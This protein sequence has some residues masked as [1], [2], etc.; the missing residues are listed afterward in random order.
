MR[1]NAFPFIAPV[2]PC[3]LLAA[4]VCAAPLQLHVSPEGADSWSGMWAKR[5]RFSK[6]EGPFRTLE[7]ARNEIREQK[8]AGSLPEDG[9][10]VVLEPGVYELPEP[11][12]LTPEDS[13][14]QSAPIV[15]RAA[16]RGTAIL[17]GGVILGGWRPADTPAAQ[18][19][20]DSAAAGRLLCTD[21]GGDLID[22]IPG[23]ANGGCGF[24]GEA[25]YPLALY[26]AS[27]R[28]PISRWP[29]S[30]FV[31]VGECL[32]HNELHGHS[33]IAFT[34]G[35]FRFENGRL[36]RW[37][38][39][40]ELWFD[41]LWFHHWADQ[42]M[43][44]KAIDPREQTISL[45][46]P[47]THRFGYK[48][49][50]GFFAFNAIGEIDRPGE[51]AVDRAER[52]IHL[53]PAADPARNPVTLA[54]R[55]NLIQAEGV[56]DIHFEDLV[57]E[58][59]LETAIVVRN[60]TRVSVSGSTVRHTGSWG[61]DID[62]GSD[63]TVFGCDLYDLGEGGVKASGGIQETLTPGNHVIENNHIHHFGVVVNTYRYGAAVYGVG[64]TIRHNLL[65]HAQHTALFFRGNDHL[66]E[67]N[68]IHDVCLHSSDAGAIHPCARDW[69]LRGCVIRHNFFHATG[70][71]VD[72]CGCHGIYLDD[73]T[74]GV[75]IVGNICSMV[76][77][78][79]TTCG[80]GNR[81]ENNLSIN[82][83]KS[84]FELS[85]RG[86]DSFARAN[87]AKGTE[88]HLVKKLLAKGSPYRSETWKTRYPNLT[89]LLDMLETDPVGAHDSHFCTMR[90]NVNA[91]GLPAHVRNEKNVMRTSTIKNNIDVTGD[92]GFVDYEN[93][94]LRLRADSVVFKELPD[95]KPLQFEKMG[96]Y[97]SP[98]RASPAVKFG[99]DITPMTPIMS[100]AERERDG[101]AILCPVP[102]ASVPIAIDGVL[103]PDEW[104]R[105]TAPTALLK[106]EGMTEAPQTSRV[107]MATDADSLY[108]AFQNDIAPRERATR[109]HQ[110]GT[111]D[112][113]E[114]ALA[115]LH[116][117]RIPIGL[118]TV[119]LRGYADGH[120]EC[121]TDG[122]LPDH[123]ARRL[124][125]KVT[126]AARRRYRGAW[127]AEWRIPLV[128]LDLAPGQTNW[129]V[130]THLC[131]YQAATD[132]TVSWRQRRVLHTWDVRQAYALCLDAF[133][134]VPFAPGVPP[135][136]V[137]IDVQADR[138]AESPTLAPGEGATMPEWARKWNRIVA[139]L[140]EASADKW[141]TCR[142][143]FMPLSD[144]VVA[145]QIMGTYAN[146]HG[147]LLS[148]WTYYDDF[149]V[150][151]AELVNGD[152]ETVAAN[153]K[154]DGW[155]CVCDQNWQSTPSSES[156]VVEEARLAASGKRMAMACCEH[157]V[158]QEMKVVKGRMVTVQFQAR[159]TL[160]TPGE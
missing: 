111:D 108:V 101:R 153:G 102:P 123:Q 48:A 82:S 34:E 130:L 106:W 103:G 148:T 144:G 5:K 11:F 156:G 75:T 107:W 49:G 77:H 90:N 28:L 39:E 63:C 87:A 119:I 76:G 114:I 68:I 159:G 58:H 131:A 143:E 30:G 116:S 120:F 47:E 69:T 64:N 65:H 92:P 16:R 43:Q 14:A 72:G 54:L 154:L 142:F 26:Q 38:A 121:V 147:S 21:I 160:P 91:G 61:V 124:E 56:R 45:Q 151:G 88:S 86:L 71:G 117:P 134:P 70:K 115:P 33:G 17:S 40:P 32:G 46:D 8:T 136:E 24:A 93:F 139:E 83:R 96:L 74:S 89:P 36:A 44:L 7:R 78:S 110:W 95:F 98:R 97:D 133:G 59:T 85:S 155:E 67:Y 127:S 10:I 20:V 23:F 150:E 126:Y 29:N 73:Y 4:Q 125:Q 52:R 105:N 66:V 51:W 9:V 1:I 84:S 13:G 137:R 146:A 149:T 129:P 62:G 113:V 60:A 27:E 109:G 6:T 42:K 55:K 152:F 81:I 50:Q 80:N 15:Y 138:E 100:P 128:V 53:W 157:R 37:V 94:D 18:K 57:F 41:G 12:V 35:R 19:L 122:G 132:R 2:F 25:Q 104:P 135:S 3:C 145:L 112:G 22:A 31:K 141:K 140:G 158:V 118:T 99:A 79:V